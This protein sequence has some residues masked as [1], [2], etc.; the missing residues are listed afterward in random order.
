MGITVNFYTFTKKY[1][2]T[3]QPTGDGTSLTCNIKAPSSI[4][5][6]RLEVATNP[7]AYNYV[8]I[9]T[10]GRYYFITDITFNAGVWVCNLNEDVLATYKSYIGASSL[11]VTRSATQYNEYIRD[12]ILA[13]TAYTTGTSST[14]DNTI[15][16]WN[17]G[18]YVVNT[19]T[20]SAN[21]IQSYQMTP[22]QFKAFY[23]ELFIYVNGLNWTDVEHALRNEATGAQDYIVSMFWFPEAFTASDTSDVYLGPATIHTGAKKIA[24]ILEKNYTV[25]IPKHPKA[26]TYGKYLNSEPYSHYTLIFGPLSETAIDLSMYVDYNTVN[27]K[28]RV[29][30]ATG[31]A[32]ISLTGASFT[33]GWG[34]P[35]PIA[36]TNSNMVGSLVSGS[37]AIANLLVGNYAGAIAGAASAAANFA[38]TTSVTSSIGS[39]CGHCAGRFLIGYFADV[40]DQDITNLGRPLCQVTTPASL[41]GYMVVQNGS[42]SAPANGSELASIKGYLEGG[43]YYE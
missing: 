5:N 32:T 24:G 38:G 4:I 41:T 13:T 17:N 33:V 16:T 7:T 8:K 43:F 1:N 35:I 30:P 18:V 21:G 10:F 39:I 3:K 28:L 19:V 12:N 23:D 27:I 11:Y 34:V 40:T 42:I 9:A 37:A 2:S 15:Y 31:Q 20:N 22:A 14:I 36:K 25:T 6:P 26:A 29:D